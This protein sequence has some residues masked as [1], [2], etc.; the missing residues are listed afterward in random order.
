M[1]N[2]TLASGAA[3]L[4]LAA[5]ACAPYTAQAY[6]SDS[7]IQHDARIKDAAKSDAALG[8]DLDKD[9]RKK[10]HKASKDAKRAAHKAKVAAKKADEAA[11]APSPG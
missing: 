11:G 10:A 9:A 2:K 4:V 3:A 8:K 5:L 6:P 7:T 1:R